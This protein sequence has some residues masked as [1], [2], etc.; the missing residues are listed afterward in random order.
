MF[1]Q[2]YTVNCKLTHSPSAVYRVL[3]FPLPL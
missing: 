1:Q 2:P 3:K